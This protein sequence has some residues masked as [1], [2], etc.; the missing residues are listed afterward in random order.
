MTE[1]HQFRSLRAMCDQYMRL[2]AQEHGAID[3]GQ[4]LIMRAAFMCGAYGMLSETRRFLDI[5]ETQYVK[6]SE[7]LGNSA[8]AL[9]I[10]K[11]SEPPGH[12]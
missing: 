10:L 3:A 5:F 12:G 1:R 11:D 4:E 9:D 6:L 7:E 2:I 8:E